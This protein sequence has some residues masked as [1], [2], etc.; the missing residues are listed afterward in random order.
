MQL[1]AMTDLNFNILLLY[2]ICFITSCSGGGGSSNS[3][4]INPAS[5][6]TINPG[7]TSG[8]IRTSDGILKGYWST[9]N[10][11]TA[12]SLKC[13]EGPVYYYDESLPQAKSEGQTIQDF[14]N[15]SNTWSVTIQNGI[16]D[17]FT[18]PNKNYYAQR[19]KLDTCNGDWVYIVFDLST[20]TTTGQFYISR[21]PTD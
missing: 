16:I 13:K 12:A 21:L 19:S 4:P 14:F 2:S 8:N 9:T 17:G 18:L 1:K 15:P 11:N 6:N 3:T 7:Q 5:G 10:D 20:G